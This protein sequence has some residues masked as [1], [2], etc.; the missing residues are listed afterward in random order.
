MLSKQRKLEKRNTENQSG[1]IFRLQNSSTLS[2]FARI[3]S[4]WQSCWHVTN[5]PCTC[6]RY[7]QW[8]L[9]SKPVE[10][11]HGP[12]QI[13]QQSSSSGEEFG[14]KQ[15]SCCKCAKKMRQ[16]G[17][18][19]TKWCEKSKALFNCVSI[20]SDEGFR[21]EERI[22]IILCFNGLRPPLRLWM[23]EKYSFLSVSLSSTRY[24]VLAFFG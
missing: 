23:C 1:G 12:K 14:R 6:I 7:I 8:N 2:N 19:S 17:I 4:K 5:E 15:A 9:G 3:Q 18:Q 11:G 22:R 21:L 24:Y 16:T 13:M 20:W 10:F